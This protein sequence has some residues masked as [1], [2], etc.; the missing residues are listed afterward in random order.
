[1]KKVIDTNILINYP[2]VIL[3]N[4]CIIPSVVISELENIKTGNKRDE[5]LKFQARVAVRMLEDNSDKYEIFVVNK[6]S[7]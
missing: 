1:M 2:E 4:D 6:R 5:N 3:E 7:I